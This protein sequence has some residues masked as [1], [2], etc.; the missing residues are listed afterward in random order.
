MITAV[1][2][3]EDAGFWSNDGVDFNA[4][5]VA[6]R[7][8]LKNNK[9]MSGGSTITMQ[10]VKNLFL[11]QKRTLSR[12]AQELFL[13]WHLHNTIKKDRLMEIYLNIIEF[14]PGIYGIT[15]AAEHFFR[16]TPFDLN[17]KEAV[18]LASVLPSPIRRY[19]QFCHGKLSPGY[20]DLLSEK[21]NQMYGQ[22]R[23]P[24]ETVVET[25]AIMLNFNSL[26]TS[27]QYTCMNLENSQKP[28][29][30]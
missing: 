30:V 22:G 26:P 8:N 5:D 12:K 29:K 23:I 9:V 21:L 15:Q 20:E 24:M 27:S 16:K 6:L 13:S 28:K 1:V 25:R 4:I 19:R 11:S 2:S 18:F 3:S 14:G 7:N 17:L 10:T